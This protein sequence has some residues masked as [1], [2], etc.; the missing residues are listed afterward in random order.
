M[1]C[2]CVH[3]L[4]PFCILKDFIIYLLSKIHCSINSMICINKEKA[5]RKGSIHQCGS[6]DN[7]GLILVSV[8]Q[9]WQ[10]PQKSSFLQRSNRFIIIISEKHLNMTLHYP[11]ANVEIHFHHL[12]K[13][14]G[15]SINTEN[16]IPSIFTEQILNNRNITDMR[17]SS[18][19]VNI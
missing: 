10:S 4:T 6:A 3:W 15:M 7:I 8:A 18:I 14:Q 5:H 16:S 11:V 13:K 17:T 9:E 2:L 19:I 1:N 12:H